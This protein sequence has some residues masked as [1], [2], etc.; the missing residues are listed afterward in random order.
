MLQ[1]VRLHKDR[2]RGSESEGRMI[3]KV[4]YISGAHCIGRHWQV[5]RTTKQLSKVTCK[6]CLK[7]TSHLRRR[8]R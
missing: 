2:Q 3:P 6:K 4:H 7:Q 1:K 8:R 5:F